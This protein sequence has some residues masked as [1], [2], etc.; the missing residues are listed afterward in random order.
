[1]AK[2]KAKKVLTPGSVGRPRKVKEKKGT[3]RLGN[4]RSKYSEETFLKALQA[5]KDHRMSLSTV[6]G[7]RS[8]WGLTIFFK[9]MKG[10]RSYP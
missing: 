3:K 7:P 6:V 5:V 10:G 1:M 4:Y 9:N 2:I 8:F